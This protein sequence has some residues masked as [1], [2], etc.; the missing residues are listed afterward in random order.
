[1]LALSYKK[2]CE[3]QFRPLSMVVIL[4]DKNVFATDFGDI[5]KTFN[6]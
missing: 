1:M 6:E 3:K 2:M 4:I 5:A